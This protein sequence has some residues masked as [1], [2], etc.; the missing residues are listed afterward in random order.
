MCN[1]EFTTLLKLQ[2]GTRFQ[3][4]LVVLA[5]HVLVVVIQRLV[6]DLRGT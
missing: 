6:L 1:G 3:Y 2:L 4:R 5:T